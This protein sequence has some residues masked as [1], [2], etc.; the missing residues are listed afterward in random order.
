MENNRET[1][2]SLFKALRTCTNGKTKTNIRK[3]IK[4]L[5][6][7]DRFPK[8]FI[9]TWRQG[10]FIQFISGA[11]EREAEYKTSVPNNLWKDNFLAYMRG[12]ADKVY[13]KD[14]Y[15][16]INDA[17]YERD[18]YFEFNSKAY[19]C[20]KYIR[21][22]DKVYLQ[23]QAIQIDENG[24]YVVADKGEKFTTHLFAD[25]EPALLSLFRRS[26]IETAQFRL[27]MSCLLFNGKYRLDCSD[28]NC[29][30][31]PKSALLKCEFK[32]TKQMKNLLETTSVT[33]C[34]GAVYEGQK[35][36]LNGKMW[37]QLVTR[38]N[39]ASF[40]QYIKRLQTFAREE[41]KYEQP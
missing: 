18:M 41:A 29:F 7:V 23:S 33:D 25:N 15:F 21:F 37:E 3:I 2:V 11:T 32:P 28:A 39:K 5:T 9:S 4:A 20:K 13:T 1:L 14:E 6:P 27:M 38:S 40:E 34:F 24:T 22:A 31:I 16:R 8:G 10:R 19:Y 36:S 12:D 26:P 17:F 30:A 35:K